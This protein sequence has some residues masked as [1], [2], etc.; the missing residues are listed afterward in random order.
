MMT[1]STDVEKQD[2]HVCVL[3][4][5]IHSLHCQDF[6]LKS[7]KSIQRMNYTGWTE[8]SLLDRDNVLSTSRSTK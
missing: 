4:L 3:I 1:L 7:A 2:F 6:S 5:I 8:A